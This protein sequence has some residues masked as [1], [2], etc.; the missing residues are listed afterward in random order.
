M[1]STEVKKIIKSLNN[2]ENKSGHCVFFWNDMRC[3]IS[4]ENEL[5]HNLILTMHKKFL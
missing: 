3:F 4:E 1:K 5:I 2:I